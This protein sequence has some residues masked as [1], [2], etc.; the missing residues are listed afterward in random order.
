ML[1]CISSSSRLNQLRAAGGAGQATTE[2]LRNSGR[3]IFRGLKGTENV[4]TQ[5]EPVL[6]QVNDQCGSL[7]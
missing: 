7:I 5:H 3:K 4:F 2:L 1:D 6:S